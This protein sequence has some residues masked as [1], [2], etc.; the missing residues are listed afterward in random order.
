V[1]RESSL[2]KNI[3]RAVL[4]L[5]CSFEKRHGSVFGK[6]GD[7]DI[8]ILVPV[9]WQT[10]SIPLFVEAKAPG[11]VLRPLQEK[12]ARDRKRYKAVAIAAW[13]VEDVTRVIEALRKGQT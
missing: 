11:K 12:R 8:L 1:A 5:G 7:Q 4:K 9:E 3:E 2:I 6:T 10:Y 13:N